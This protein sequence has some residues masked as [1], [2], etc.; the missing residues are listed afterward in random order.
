[1]RNFGM[2]TRKKGHANLISFLVSIGLLSIAAI[3]IFFFRLP[4][5]R[6][7]CICRVA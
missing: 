6:P 1:M 7:F 5:F 4:R 3:F 2:L